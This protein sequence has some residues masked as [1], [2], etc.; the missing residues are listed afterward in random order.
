MLAPVKKVLS[1]SFSFPKS[2]DFPPS[3][4]DL[5]RIKLLSSFYSLSA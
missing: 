2:I 3:L 4:I 5:G 1:T